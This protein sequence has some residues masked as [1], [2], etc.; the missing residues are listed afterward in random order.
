[1]TS[2]TITEVVTYLRV[3]TGA[4][5]KSG[6]GLEAQREYVQ[7]AAR[8]HGW[9]IIAEYIETVSG[10]VAPW[11][12]PQCNEALSH[13]LPI[14]AAKVDRISRDV[15]HIAGLMKRATLKIATMPH[16]DNFQI[17]LFAALAQQ[18]RDFIASRTRD[19]LA[20]LKQRAAKGELEAV[21]KIANRTEKLA[22]GRNNTNRAKA[23]EALQSR[24]SKWS[25]T[26]RDP[27]DLCI[28]R[29]ANTL[30]E[31][32]DCMN[33]K[34]IPTSRGGKWSPIQI[35]RVMKSLSLTF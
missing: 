5:E 1:M 4:Q 21:K 3:S 27:I 30:R 33:T 8:Q 34:G 10:T 11:E 12:R 19:A 24:A 13:D 25:E 9:T 6:L 35:S 2:P 23:I 14:L 29:G 26:V 22:L 16:A 15:E 31:V 20:A 32:A 28:R 7:S 17:H 18:E